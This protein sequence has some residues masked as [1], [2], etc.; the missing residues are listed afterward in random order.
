MPPKDTKDGAAAALGR[1]RWQ[2]VSRTER[3][4]QMRELARKRWAGKRKGKK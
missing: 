4:K 3:K 2:G 1:R